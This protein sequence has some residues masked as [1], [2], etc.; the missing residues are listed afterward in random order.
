MAP[1]SLPEGAP[2]MHTRPLWQSVA[3]VH[4]P[5]LPLPHEATVPMSTAM[6]NARTQHLYHDRLRSFRARL[7]PMNNPYGPG[8]GQLPPSGFGGGPPSDDTMAWVGIACSGLS[9]LSCC[10]GPVPFVGMIGAFG[11]LL[12]AV[13]G[14]IAGWLALQNAQRMQTRTDLAK[15]AIG[16]GA[17]RVIL[18][19]LAVGAFF[20]LA[21]LGIGIAGLEAYTQHGR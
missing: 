10:C 13:G 21:M 16:L 20:V 18:T 1:A 19:V 17:A 6:A 12:L 5:P 15:I 3:A 4:R 11:G 2:V 8:P 7:A 9:W 14:I